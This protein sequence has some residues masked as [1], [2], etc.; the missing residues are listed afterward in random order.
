MHL[1]RRQ[2]KQKLPAFGVILNRG[3]RKKYKCDRD[4]VANVE[5]VDSKK[6]DPIQVADV[7][8]GAIGYQNNDCH[9]RPGARQAKIQL[10]DYVAQKAYL[11]SLKQNTPRRMRHFGIW[12]FRF[13]GRKKKTP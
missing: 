2:T 9:L 10:A 3:I 13:S 1:D 5:A 11:L 8:M 4:V 6:C 7:L 12:L